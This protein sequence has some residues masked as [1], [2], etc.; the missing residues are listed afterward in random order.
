MIHVRGK[1]Q[2]TRSRSHF[3]YSSPHLIPLTSVRSPICTRNKNI[4]SSP[5]R[6]R[7]TCGS[8]DQSASRISDI[9]LVA[10]CAPASRRISRAACYVRCSLLLQARL[11]RMEIGEGGTKLY[12]IVNRDRYANGRVSWVVKSHRL[13]SST[14]KKRTFICLQALSAISSAVKHYEIVLFKI[15]T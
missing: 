5:R 6:R 1:S 4:C 15:K 14:E 9:R 10:W 12:C 7:G 8:R 3:T 11:E 2:P 13:F